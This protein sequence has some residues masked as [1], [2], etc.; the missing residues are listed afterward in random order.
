MGV[1]CYAARVNTDFSEV[2]GSSDKM[3]GKAAEQERKIR[4]GLGRKTEGVHLFN[5][6]IK[7]FT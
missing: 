2:S 7:G 5:L 6:L 1:I 3:D 4:M